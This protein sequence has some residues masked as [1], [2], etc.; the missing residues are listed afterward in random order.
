MKTMKNYLQRN[1]LA[2]FWHG[3][4]FTISAALVDLNTV[5]PGFIINLSTSK[6]ILG[7]ATS[8]LMGGPILFQFLFIRIIDPLPFKKWTLLLG[9][10]LRVLAFL[11]MFFTSLYLSNTP[12]TAIYVLFILL[13]VFSV[14]GGFAGMS[15]IVIH[16]IHRL[17]AYKRTKKSH[18]KQG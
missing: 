5:L 14:S 2:F 18:I 16:R 13:F 4:F 17:L 3:I 10:Y 8:I 9:I 6:I 1:Y 12:L 11:G 15:Y 7:A